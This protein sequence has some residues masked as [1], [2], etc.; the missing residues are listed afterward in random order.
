MSKYDEILNRIENTIKE[1]PVYEIDYFDPEKTV[2]I[3]IDMTEGFTREG[4][5]SS[6]EVESIIPDIKRLV[7][8]AD[9]RNIEIIYF[10][11]AHSEESPEVKRLGDHCLRGT[12]ESE[13]VEELKGYE[14]IKILKNTTNGF[15][16]EDFQNWL[17][18]NIY[19]IKNYIITGCVTDICVYNFATTLRAYLDKEEIIEAELYVPV[20]CVATYDLELHQVDLMNNI[21][22]YGMMNY[23]IKLLKEIK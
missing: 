8:K 18:N 3:V 9:K 15:L 22:L 20:N 1:Q 16:A 6:P 19:N 4:I 12:S 23:G 11:D 10:A 13:I 7:Q 21:Y 17:E 5:L 14:D 2:L